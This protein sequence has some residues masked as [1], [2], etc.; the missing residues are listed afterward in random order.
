MIEKNYLS[1]VDFLR[2]GRAHALTSREL[3]QLTGT[4]PRSVR[5]QIQA[6]RLHGVPICSSTGTPSGY[7]LA[8]NTG[9]LTRFTRSMRR[10]AAEIVA[11]ADAVEGGI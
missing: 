1:V 6:A 5:L 10:R 2:T 4:D 8:S 11:V 3:V 9:E 7:F